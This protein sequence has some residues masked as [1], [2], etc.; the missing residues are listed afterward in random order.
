MRCRERGTGH[1]VSEDQVELYPGVTEALRLLKGRLHMCCH[2]QSTRCRP[3]RMHCGE[4][5]EGYAGGSTCSDR[6]A[7]TCRRLQPA[8][9]VQL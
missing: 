1:I 3:S 6:A 8:D 2:Y 4:P 7:K 5:Y 9:A